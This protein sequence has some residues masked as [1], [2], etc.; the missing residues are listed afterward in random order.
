[1][2]LSLSSPKNQAFF[3]IADFGSGS[4]GKRTPL[5]AKHHFDGVV[6]RADNNAEL[7]PLAAGFIDDGYFPNRVIANRIGLRTVSHAKPTPLAGNTI[8]LRD[9]SNRIH[10]SIFALLHED[11]GHQRLRPSNAC[12]VSLP[13]CLHILLQE[14][15]LLG[16]LLLD[17]LI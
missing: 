3:S 17:R 5:V 7:T 12:L 14:L 1:M 6:F 10:G 13:D 2:L 16:K 15:L 4:M 8:C 11:R 9:C